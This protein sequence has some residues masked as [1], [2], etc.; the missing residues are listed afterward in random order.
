MDSAF[1]SIEQ[2]VIIAI[3]SILAGRTTPAR[4]AGPS[5]FRLAA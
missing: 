1:T 2:F 5:T 3:I 4:S